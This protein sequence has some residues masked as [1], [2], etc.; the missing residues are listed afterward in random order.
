MEANIRY[1]AYAARWPCIL[2]ATTHGAKTLSNR[3]RDDQRLLVRK[4]IQQRRWA[5]L[6]DSQSLGGQHEPAW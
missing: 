5:K 6:F 2:T 4:P 3:D 1:G